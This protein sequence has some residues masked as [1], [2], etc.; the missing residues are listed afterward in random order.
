V[1]DPVMCNMPAI[2]ADECHLSCI[3]QGR[4]SFVTHFHMVLNIMTDYG[5]A[6]QHSQNMIIY[7]HV[8]VITLDSM[9]D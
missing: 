5:H 8:N 1:L 4:R 7:I 6:C 9:K 3:P 2:P